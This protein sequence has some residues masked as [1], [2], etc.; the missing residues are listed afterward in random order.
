MRVCMYVCAPACV[1]VCARVYAP[2]C[3]C[4]GVGVCRTV[5]V[6]GIC[7]DNVADWLERLHLQRGD[8][9]FDPHSDGCCIE[10]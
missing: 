7:M 4:M 9:G 5:C 1:R 8:Y 2:V 10:I 6:F 3:S